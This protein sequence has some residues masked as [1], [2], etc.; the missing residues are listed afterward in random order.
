LGSELAVLYFSSQF[1]F[2][3]VTIRHLCWQSVRLLS[4][5]SKHF[6]REMILQ[7]RISSAT[8]L[9]QW[10]YSECS[11]G[12]L[13]AVAAL[14]VRQVAFATGPGVPVL[15]LDRP[16]QGVPWGGGDMYLSYRQQSRQQSFAGTWQ[17]DFS[18]SKLQQFSGQYGR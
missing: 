3:I 18:G 14:A 4:F 16:S 7:E 5:S 15:S 9:I 12:F 2:V 1:F 11:F 8:A 13:D 17:C 6:S 10:R